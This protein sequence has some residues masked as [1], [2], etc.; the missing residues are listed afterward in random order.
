MILNS[1]RLLAFVILFAIIIIK[2]IPFKKIFKDAILQLYI[3]I[4]CIAILLIIDNI[5][6]FII[7]LAVLILY[8]RVY[9]E[10][11]KKKN[12]LEEKNKEDSPKE[13]CKHK[14]HKEHKE[15]KEHKEHNETCNKCTLDIPKKK[16][17]MDETD[18]SNGYV[19]YISEEHLLAAQT[20]II[21]TNNYHLNIDTD[22]LHKLDIKRGPLYK[23]Q[24]LPDSSDLNGEINHIRGYDISNEYL[25]SLSYDIL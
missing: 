25:G 24:G 15:D 2:D 20:N 13:Q 9:S 6:G 1:L 3:A 10:E 22:D 7:T 12:E 23:I 19:P 4:F 5:T 21:D 16:S 8:F 14:E 18:N 11:I 17:I